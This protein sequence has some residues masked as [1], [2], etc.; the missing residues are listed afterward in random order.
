MTHRMQPRGCAALRKKNTSGHQLMS[1]PS[2]CHLSTT[3]HYTP[4]VQL[5]MRMLHTLAQP[6]L[7]APHVSLPARTHAQK[8]KPL[9]Y[10]QTLIRLTSGSKNP[11]C[12]LRGRQ[13]PFPNGRLGLAVAAGLHSPA[14]TRT[15]QQPDCQTCSLVHIVKHFVADMLVAHTSCHDEVAMGRGRQQEVRQEPAYAWRG[16][17]PAL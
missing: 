13:A 7:S 11:V 5:H 6:C 17:V 3:Q 9:P 14:H 1:G 15:G 10:I 8:S 2:F 16:G 4:A 12:S